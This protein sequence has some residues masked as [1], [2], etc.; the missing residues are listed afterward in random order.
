[1]SLENFGLPSGSNPILHP[2]MSHRFRFEINSQELITLQTTKIV[3]DL[4]N[5]AFT[6]CV[7]HPVQRSNEMFQ[8]IYSLGEDKPNDFCISLLSGD[9]AVLDAI[10]G[11]AKLTKS[12]FEWNYA[13]SGVAVHELEFKYSPSAI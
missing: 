9:G 4:R 1:M 13:H 8:A 3:M 2:A 7:E 6:V 5:K 12:T 10:K 11:F